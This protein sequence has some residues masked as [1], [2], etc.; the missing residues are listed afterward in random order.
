MIRAIFHSEIEYQAGE[1]TAEGGR[2]TGYRSMGPVR[3]DNE[4]T[5]DVTGGHTTRASLG[6]FSLPELEMVAGQT[7][8]VRPAIHRWPSGG[9]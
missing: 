2:R 3:T 5:G 7:A 1:R 9:G 4:L 6:L 8:D